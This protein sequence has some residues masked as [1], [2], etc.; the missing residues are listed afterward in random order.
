MQHTQS[1]PKKLAWLLIASLM[2]FAFVCP[3]VSG[4]QPGAKPLQISEVEFMGLRRLTQ[5]Q[6]L[7]ISGLQPGDLF[8][9]ALVDE[10]AKKLMD[11]GLFVRLGFRVKG[12]GNLLHVTFQVEEADRGLPIIFDN[13]VWFTDEELVAGIRREVQFFNGTVPQSGSAAD[14]IAN[15][16]QKLLDEKK[17][18]GR[19]EHL[20]GEDLAHNLSYVFSVKGIELPV[21]T[22]HFPGSAGVSEDDLRKAAKQLI[23]RDYSKSSSSAF[24]SVTLIPLYRH[25]GR[26]RAKFNE[27]VAVLDQSGGPGCKNGVDL[28]IPVEEGAVYSWQKAEWTGNQSVASSALDAALGMKAGEVADGIKIDKGL[29]E[30]AKAFGH[31]GFVTARIKQSIQFDETNHLVTF[32]MD[33][34]EGQQYRMGDLITRGLSPDIA[35][36][37]R[38]KWAL[39]TGDVFDSTYADEFMKNEGRSILQMIFQEHHAP[40]TISSKPNQQ[41]LTVDVTFEVK[42]K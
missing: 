1:L 23:D 24:A 11:S 33:V 2:V 41:T 4:Q 35:R 16:L 38:E 36:T 20:A 32:K 12:A 25:V 14:T 40:P 7:A 34:I 15:A 21:C 3:G 37:I 30:V 29:K 19:I 9:E 17:I 42:R 18:A 5:Q 31:K 39:H 10:A 22:L 13:F 27:P 28:T 26:L 8:S 6:A